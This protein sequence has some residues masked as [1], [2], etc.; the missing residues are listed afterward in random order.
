MNNWQVQSSHRTAVKTSEL[1]RQKT[2]F[3]FKIPIRDERDERKILYL[4]SAVFRNKII[5]STLTLFVV[6][7][8]IDVIII[9]VAQQGKPKFSHP[10]KILTELCNSPS[11][12]IPFYQNADLRFLMN[13]VICSILTLFTNCKHRHQYYIGIIQIFEFF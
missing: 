9:G 5:R 7:L 3:S 1:V 2:L 12:N 6:N 4:P 8:G 10:C 11:K 13:T